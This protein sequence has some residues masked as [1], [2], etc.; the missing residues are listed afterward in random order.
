MCIRDRLEDIPLIMANTLKQLRRTENITK[1][2]ST[3]A[4]SLLTMYSWPGN[5]RELIN[6]VERLVFMEDSSMI[7]PLHVKNA[8]NM[9][10]AEENGAEDLEFS[11]LEQSVT[12]AESEA[13]VKA[14]LLYTSRCV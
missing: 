4:L 7:E 5:V 9:V 6:V 10:F 12:K 2:F 8:L 1:S 13:I 11:V 14:C 3:E